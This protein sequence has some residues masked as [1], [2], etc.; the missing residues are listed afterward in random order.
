[1]VIW[2][3]MVDTF[4]KICVTKY[5]CFFFV[6]GTTNNFTLP[7]LHFLHRTEANRS[8]CSQYEG[9]NKAWHATTES[10]GQLPD[11]SIER[12]NFS[13]QSLAAAA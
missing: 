11:I 8:F 13:M 1:M 3:M 7:F 10:S 4:K 5:P 12:L 9:L 6:N 2:L